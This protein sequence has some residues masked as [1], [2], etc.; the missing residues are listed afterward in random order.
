MKLR[1]VRTIDPVKTA[2]RV[3][4]V[5]DVNLDPWPATIDGVTPAAGDRV[6]LKEQD[7]ASENGIYD[8]GNDR[9]RDANEL[10]DGALGQMVFVAEGDVNAGQAFVVASLVPARFDP[11]VHRRTLFDDVADRSPATANGAVQS[12]LSHT[13]SGGQLARDMD[14]LV[15]RWAGTFGGGTSNR[16]LQVGLASV[17]VAA[18]GSFAPGG[19]SWWIETTVIR[20]SATTARVTTLIGIGT[21]TVYTSSPQY[22]GVTLPGSGT[23][24]DAIP[25]TLSGSVSSGGA[26]TDLV[27]RL[28]TV[29]WVAAAPN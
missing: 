24:L 15:A 12:V 9:S 21:A 2:V 14:K 19:G 6:L 29:E 4:S 17:T 20:A 3:A 8:F 23:F 25:I 7:D 18:T 1:S 27:C 5:G 10:G 22:T 16:E 13:L 11:V 26:T 28:A